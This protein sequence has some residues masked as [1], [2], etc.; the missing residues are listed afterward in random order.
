LSITQKWGNLKRNYAAIWALASST[1]QD[2]VRGNEGKLRG[3]VE[4]WV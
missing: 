3:K 2:L 4:V 1:E